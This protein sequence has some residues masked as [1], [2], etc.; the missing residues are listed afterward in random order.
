MLPLPLKALLRLYRA[1]PWL[2]LMSLVGLTL[3]VS[4]VVAIELLNHSA[5]T[6]FVA[7]RSQL[8]GEANYRLAPDGGLDEQLYVTLVRSQ[9]N[10][11]A[12]PE[13]H[14]WLQDEQGRSFQLLGMDLFN[15]GPLRRLFGAAP[16]NK[17]TFSLTRADSI[18]LAAPEARRLGWQ[19]G[20]S[21]R[22]ALGGAE[23]AQPRPLTLTLAGTFEPG[24]VPMERLLV[25]D[26]GLA[27][28]LLG[29]EGRLDRI[30]FKLSEQEASALQAA[31]QAYAPKQPLWL[32]PISPALDASQ[33]GDALALNLTALSLLA[34]AVGLFLVFNAQR[35]VQSVRRPQLAQLIILGMP[36]R[37]LLR[38]LTLEILILASIGTLLGLLLGSFLALALMGQLTQALAD[39]YGPNP[40]DLLRLSPASLIKAL[41]IGLLGTL[42]A[43]LPGWWQLLR[44]SPLALREGNSRPPAHP[45]QRR[46]LAIAILLL[47][48]LCLWRPE[49][50]LGGALFV[51]GGWLLAMALLLPD[52]LRWLL[53]RLR[54]RGPLTARLGVAET[55]Y[56]L[57]R[58]AI[59]VMA[60]QLAIA[61]A[62]GIGVMVSS[63]RSSVEIWLGQ[64]LAADLYV[65]APKG[66]AGSKGALSEQTLDT[67]LAAPDVRAASRRS[68]HPA[69]W[70]G[71]PIE[72]AQMDFIPELK[73]AY[74]LLAGRWPAT[75]DEVLAS[76][77]LTVRLGV[78]VGQSLEVSGEQGP[79]TL[80]VT[81]VYQD[82]GSDKGQILHAFEGG[83]VQSL[84]LF[85][86]DPEH[87]GDRLRSQFGEQVNLLPAPAI[88]AAALKVFDQTFVVTEL[89]KLLILGIAFVGIGSAFMVLGLARR[90]ELQT[91][92]S[93]G[94]S[95]RHCRRLLVWQGAG[96]GLLTAL[97]ALPVGYGLAWVLIEVVNPRAF[98]WRLAFEAAPLHAV[99]ALLLAP[100]CGA[101]ASWYAARRVV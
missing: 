8:A 97:L 17:P 47:C 41:L 85:S 73:A 60:L 64:R 51:A 53:G 83:K 54:A 35:F 30:V 57:D 49:T 89:L 99:T 56:H 93:L 37:R 78:K 39:L 95:P 10:L 100:V 76:E 68:V 27:Q 77:P 36:P 7:A 25:T 24:A 96:L 44:Q 40:I 3:G 33:L 22:F 91:L 12:M 46:G 62:I 92:Q 52:A 74:P 6:N 38:W 45:W 5:R 4:L 16:D 59:A 14:G 2:L 71:Q 20:Q 29:K 80:I 32:E 31:L 98:G 13:L 26:I 21:R 50:G 65:T 9:P 11:D 28:P 34:M 19:P 48:A 87:L 75:P 63:F 67:I 72:W 1:H 23:G 55:L 88:H 86:P 18:W 15:P 69:R 101:L 84:A 61:A 58:T 82:Y 66:V 79:S 94:L 90:G 70:Q 42:A 81:G 43:N